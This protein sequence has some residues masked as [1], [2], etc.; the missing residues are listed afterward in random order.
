VNGGRAAFTAQIL[1]RRLKV[2][3]WAPGA[4]LEGDPNTQAV[5]PRSQGDTRGDPPLQGLNGEPA[6]H[7]A[8]HEYLDPSDARALEA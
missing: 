1:I 2:T 7:V 8:I 6:P 5:A 3:G 4:A